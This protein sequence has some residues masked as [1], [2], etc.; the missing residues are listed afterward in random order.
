MKEALFYKKLENNNVQCNLCSQRCFI[1]EGK[2]GICKVRKNIKGVLYSLVYEKP[3]AR[4]I[5]PIE[6]KP[7]FHFFPASASY[8][9]AT[10]GCN[11]KCLHCQNA[12]ISQVPENT[13]FE[14]LD[15]FPASNVVEEALRY[16]CKSISYTYTEPT[17]FLEYAY[18]CAKLA[19]E[20]GIYNTFISNGYM[21]KEA[22]DF[23]APYLNAFNVDLKSFSEKFYQDVCS[24]KLNPVLDLLKYIKKLGIW[25]EVTTL[26]IPELN[27]SETE[28]T[29]IA[30]FIFNELGSE[31]P[32]HVTRFYPAY[33][34]S[35]L[36]PQSIEKVTIAREI[37]KSVGLKYVYTGNIPDSEGENTYC[38]NCGRILIRRLGYNVVEYN[39]KEG[40]CVFCNTKID[41][42]G[43]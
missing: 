11:F 25:L 39:I 28:L 23:I 38:Y 7:L 41:G 1:P 5:D 37:G 9:I 13:N 40:K 12:D 43:I 14:L 29:E 32:W 16:N 36:A 34:L 22:L 27:D 20:K 21:T 31:T 33:K 35:D 4:H 19:Q 18:E 26:L 2:F 15:T 30:Q 3:I 8:S 42:V 24:A 10:L 6:K 17:I